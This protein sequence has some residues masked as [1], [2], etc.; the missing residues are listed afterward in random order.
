MSEV[1]LGGVTPAGSRQLGRRSSIC[2]AG[3]TVVVGCADGSVRAFDSSL[4]ELWRDDGVE[5]SVVALTDFAGGVLAGERGANGTLTYYV[6]GAVRWRYRTA[7]DLGAPQQDTRFFLPFVAD[8]AATGDRVY[9]ASRRYE[10]GDDGNRTFVSVVYAFDDAGDVQWRHRTDA[11]PISLAVD[12]G[13]VAVAYNRC[14]GTHRDGLAVLDAETGEVSRRWDPPG[15]GQR[16]VGDVAFLDGRLAVASHADYRGYVLGGDGVEWSVDL[17]RPV[18][19]GDERV[20]AY[21]NHV[22]ATADG[23]V[24]VTGNTFPEDGRETDR[25]HPNEHTAVGFDADGNR[26]WRSSVGGFAHAVAADGHRVVAP[27]AQHFRDRDP[28]RHGFDVYGVQSGPESS[29]RT[30]GVVTAVAVDANRIAAVEEPVA[31]HDG[32]VEHGAYRLRLAE[33]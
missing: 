18:E 1:G 15:D 2:F 31:Y 16:R 23:V 13:R 12:D 26:R 14:P 28:G 11:S 4:D 10:R 29:E 5:G 21:P 32:D 25:R 22:R 9:V 3:E 24:F 27:A 17:A 33:T 7:A 19:R 6:D 8:A 30:P 20:Y